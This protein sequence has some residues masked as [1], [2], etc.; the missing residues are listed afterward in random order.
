MRCGP[1]PVSCLIFSKAWALLSVGL[2][3]SGWFLLRRR[4]QLVELWR[5]EEWILIGSLALGFTGL[6]LL[7]LHLW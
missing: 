4:T 3:G 2:L 7:I 5:I 6:I 1:W